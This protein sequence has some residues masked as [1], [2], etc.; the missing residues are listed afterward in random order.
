[1]K[2]DK[3]FTR[4]VARGLALL[5]VGALSTALAD[6][7]TTAATLSLK[8]LIAR[9]VQLAPTQRVS[10]ASVAIAQAQQDASRASLLPQLSASA[11][12]MRETTNPA[13]LGF[14]SIPGFALPSLIGPFSVFDARVQVSQKL[15]D[16]AAVSE[17][18]SA[19]FAHQAAEAQAEA[20][21]ESIASRVAIA[22]IQ[23]LGNE[24]AVAS[25]QADL[26]LANDLLTLSRDQRNA[27][28]ASGID[29]SRA[30]TS[31]AQDRYALSQ[32][33][34]AIAQARLRLQRMAVLPMDTVPELSGSLDHIGAVNIDAT[35]ALQTANA[36]RPEL[37]AIDASIKQADATLSAARRKR[38]PT[39]SVVADYGLSASSP[40]ENQEDT[41]R[42]GAML[43]L[44]IYA[45]G[46]IAA[47]ESSA[48]AQ[49]EQ[50]R[51]QLDDLRQQIEEDVRLSIA[52]V[53]NTRE[54]VRAAAAAREL[55][56]RELE[57][58]RDRFANGVADNVD[59]IRAQTSLANARAQLIGAQAAF[60]QARVNLAA[61]QGKAQQFDL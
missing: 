20:S 17:L 10:D 14:S 7:P 46:A 56:E 18:H 27:G 2:T 12:Q 44:P 15:V 61:A 42:Y 23:V 34:T 37:V 32:A 1:M 43:S 6:A 16:L 33:Q 28:V 48:R 53:V 35:Q 31:V 26:D 3:T 55:A 8:D 49:L 22:Y 24:E 21:R 60:Q 57:Q 13:A 29:V 54:Q 41:Y 9:A 52:T 38:L 25:A 59:V 47:Q 40:G 19:E 51:A 5:T 50:Q 58:A 36:D 11:S 4:G 30:E 39:L 45:G